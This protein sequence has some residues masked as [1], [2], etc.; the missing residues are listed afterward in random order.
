MADSIALATLG[1]FCISSERDGTPVAA[2]DCSD[3]M[4]GSSGVTLESVSSSVRNGPPRSIAAFS[5]ADAMARATSISSRGSLILVSA[6]VR[7][8]VRS[9]VAEAC[10]DR[11]DCRAASSAVI[12][13]ESPSTCGVSPFAASSDA[14]RCSSA[15]VS[16]AGALA[17][18]C[19]RLLIS[20]FNAVISS[21]L[22]LPEFEDGRIPAYCMLPA[23][24]SAMRPPTIP[25]AMRPEVAACFRSACCVVV[26]GLADP[27][28]EVVAE[29]LAEEALPD[30]LEEAVE[31]KAGFEA[32]AEVAAA[33]VPAASVVG[34]ASALRG[35]GACETGSF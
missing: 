25:A 7:R 29:D 18:C 5:A 10:A 4:A 32:V 21:F 11:S 31:P 27:D 16:A 30:V 20:V 15:D 34:F 23:A 12:F 1:N 35:V 22:E 17:S 6:S 13:S 14:I 28:D 26:D 8:R 3:A 33:L 19:R 24:A 2:K 9:A